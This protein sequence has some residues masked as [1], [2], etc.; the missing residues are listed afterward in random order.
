MEPLGRIG[1]R[2][3]G[4]FSLKGAL[5]ICHSATPMSRASGFGSGTYRSALALAAFSEG[6]F[7][8]VMES[9]RFQK[10]QGLRPRLAGLHALTI[11]IFLFGCWKDQFISKGGASFLLSVFS[12]AR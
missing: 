3:D 9:S 5:P 8:D 12:A 10:E 11:N 7:Y 2:H 4:L 1:L 6:A